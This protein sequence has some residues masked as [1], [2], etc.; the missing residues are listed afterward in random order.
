MQTWPR[1]K[2]VTEIHNLCSLIDDVISAQ[3]ASTWGVAYSSHHELL[4]ILNNCSIYC[5]KYNAMNSTTLLVNGRFLNPVRNHGL[6][7]LQSLGYQ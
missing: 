1:F 5:N 3:M 2:T 7:F 4:F 6:G